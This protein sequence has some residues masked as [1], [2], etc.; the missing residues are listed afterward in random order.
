MFGRYDEELITGGTRALLG[1]ADL[2][3]RDHGERRGRRPPRVHA[4]R[5]RADVALRGRRH[6]GREVDRDA[7]RTQRVC[8]LYRLLA[9]PA[10][11]LHT[12]PYAIFRRQDAPLVTAPAP[13]RLTI[14]RRTP[15]ARARREP[16]RLPLPGKPA[17]ACSWRTS[18]TPACALYR[19]ERDRGYEHVELNFSPGYFAVDLR[20]G[21]PVTFAGHHRRLGRSL[22]VDGEEACRAERTA[23]RGTARRCAAGGTRRLPC[24]A[25]SRRRPVPGAARQPARG[26]APRRCGRH[27]VRTVIAGYHW[28]GDWGRDTMIGLEGLTLV[29]GRRARRRLSCARSPRYVRDGLLPNLFPEGE[30]EGAI[31]TVDATLWYFHAIERYRRA[32]RRVAT[33]CASSTRCSRR[34]SRTTSRGTR[35][36]I[37]VDPARRPARRG[38]RGWR[39][40]GWTRGRH[41]VVTPRRGKP[42]EIQALWY[43]ALA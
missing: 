1:G 3:E 17:T 41:W 30:R 28:F 13:F 6:H 34:S 19:E 25:R 15:R 4:R 39:S 21:R 14:E 11:R 33:S 26:G 22:E 16:A 7:A 18:A 35:F 5:A 29:T 38:Q 12:R 24:A 37:G 40:P 27:R 9:G 23:H 32:P 31:H 42:V 36:G 8:V 10:V 20:P 2:E 43:N